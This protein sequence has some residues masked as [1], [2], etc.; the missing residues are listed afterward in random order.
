MNDKAPSLYL[1]LCLC[2]VIIHHPMSLELD[3][4]LGGMPLD[5]VESGCMGLVHADMLQHSRYSLLS[6]IYPESKADSVSLMYACTVST[7]IL[8]LLQFGRS[9][10]AV[11]RRLKGSK[12]QLPR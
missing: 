9:S 8:Y 3:V 6:C 1:G 12:G 5:L 10:L 2:H 7:A 11:S 4:G